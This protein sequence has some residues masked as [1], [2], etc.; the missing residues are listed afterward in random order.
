M[1]VEGFSAV[2]V[3][4]VVVEVVVEVEVELVIDVVAVVVVVVVEVSGRFSLG[5]ASL[6]RF[7]SQL[8]LK[9][10]SNSETYRKCG[11][12]HFYNR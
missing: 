3:E 4:E 2:V 10:H 11:V 6:Q 1:V 9:L 5:S 8:K 7:E 12:C